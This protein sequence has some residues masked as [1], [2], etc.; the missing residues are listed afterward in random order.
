MTTES[1][2]TYSNTKDDCNE[3]NLV[4]SPRDTSMNMKNK[5]TPLIKKSVEL[6]NSVSNISNVAPYISTKID[7]RFKLNLNKIKNNFNFNDNPTSFM[8][9]TQRK[10]IKMEA[11]ENTCSDIYENVIFVSGYKVAKNTALLNQRG[12]THILNCAGDYCPNLHIGKYIYKTYFIK[13]SKVENI[14]CI[15]YDSIDF[16]EN[17]LENNGKILVHC[18]QGVSRSV[19]VVIAYLMFK[20]G[21]PYQIISDI[22]RNARGVASPN[23]GFIAQLINFQSRL[24][25]KLIKY[26][27]PKIFV[28]GSHQIEDPKSIVCRYVSL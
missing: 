26:N 15:F 6:K 1:V 4:N 27:Y 17:C 12:I 18:V 20:L 23:I 7:T 10:L 3:L 19:T 28:V 2:K 16:I 25:N 21:K 5:K 8:G 13:D 14:E 22:V 9:E 24:E 11:Y